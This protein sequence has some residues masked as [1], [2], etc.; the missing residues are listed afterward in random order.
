MICA[1]AAICRMLGRGNLYGYYEGMKNDEDAY[2][3]SCDFKK[4]LLILGGGDN[5]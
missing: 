4:H 3:A 5:E 2:D 1:A